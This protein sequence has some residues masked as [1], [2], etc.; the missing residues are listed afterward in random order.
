MFCK[1][2]ENKIQD[3]NQQEYDEEEPESTSLNEF[4]FYLIAHLINERIVSNKNLK[5]SCE[6]EQETCRNKHV[7]SIKI[8]VIKKMLYQK[9]LFSNES[10]DTQELCT[11]KTYNCTNISSSDYNSN[12]NNNINNNN[13]L[14]LKQRRNKRGH[15]RKYESDQLN[16]A[17]GAVLNGTMSGNLLIF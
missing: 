8:R 15:Y 3:C 11:N 4:F 16:K 13:N 9:L 12:S 5:P 1:L 6:Q 7:E 10:L 17:V 2:K 14:I